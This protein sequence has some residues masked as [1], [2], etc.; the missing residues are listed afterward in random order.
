MWLD[1]GTAFRLRN[2]IG[3]QPRLAAEL[4]YG[5]AVHHVMSAVTES[6]HATGQVPD[7]G[8]MTP[9]STRASSC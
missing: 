3:F 7:P 5:N 1:C 4:G 2:L 9:S 6:T 8:E